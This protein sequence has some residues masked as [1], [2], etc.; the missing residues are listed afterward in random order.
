MRSLTTL[1]PKKH[2]DSLFPFAVYHLKYPKNSVIL[3][4]HWHSELEFLIVTDG[5][6]VFQL[7]ESELVLRKGQGTIINGGILHRARTVSGEPCR[8]IALVLDPQF[9]SGSG[10]DRIKIKYI[11]PVLESLKFTTPVFY[12]KNKSDSIIIDE[13]LNI[14]NISVKQEL[15]Y[16]V[17]VKIGLLK[18][19]SLLFIM[20]VNDGD[21]LNKSIPNS[22]KSGNIK[23]SLLYIHKNY[24]LNIKLKNIAVAAGMSEAYFSRT[25]KM[26]VGKTVFEY[27]HY[28][29]INCAIQLMRGTTVPISLIA[30]QVGYE[31]SSYFIKQFKKV[32]DV[33]PKVYRTSFSKE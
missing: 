2:G 5:A 32:V 3:D 13:L 25:F 33:T 16:E 30:Q 12:N 17:K 11:N 15:L 1:E 9:I 31:S 28:Y 24:H 26:L 21:T 6:G 22:S 19:F 7:A 4:L 23:E 14:A 10:N 20:M 18:V 27:I 8:F 29:R